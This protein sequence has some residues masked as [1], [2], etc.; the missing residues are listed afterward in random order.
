M[1]DACGC[2]HSHNEV[3]ETKTVDV[4]QSLLKANEEAAIANKKHFDEKGFAFFTSYN[5]RKGQEQSEYQI[6][7]VDAFA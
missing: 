3:K 1:C 5:S 6:P 2:D 7:P 4:N